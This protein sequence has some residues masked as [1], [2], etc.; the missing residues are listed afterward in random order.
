MPITVAFTYFYTILDNFELNWLK[1]TNSYY[2]I[3]A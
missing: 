1:Y 3:P 2:I